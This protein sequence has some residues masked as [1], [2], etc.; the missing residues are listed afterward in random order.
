MRARV[1]TATIHTYRHI[2]NETQT[3]S[4]RRR[5]ERMLEKYRKEQGDCMRRLCWLS[6]GIPLENA[7]HSVDV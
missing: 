1:S 5:S 4:H 7:N 2:L 6:L 3:H